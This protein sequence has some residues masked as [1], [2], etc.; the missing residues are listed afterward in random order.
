MAPKQ[1]P[2]H[3]VM[4]DRRRREVKLRPVRA[5]KPGRLAMAVRP[6]TVSHWLTRG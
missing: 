4:L 1:K 3:T 6:D 2:S 5:V